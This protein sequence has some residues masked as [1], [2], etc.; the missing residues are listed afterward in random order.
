MAIAVLK[1]TSKRL[2]VFLFNLGSEHLE[3]FTTVTD[4]ST[5]E[6]ILQSLPMD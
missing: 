2:G 4:T 5:L 6:K 3:H 1:K